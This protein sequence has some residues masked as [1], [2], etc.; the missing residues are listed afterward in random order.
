MQNLLRA[1]E[2]P[3]PGVSLAASTGR[4]DSPFV[5]D[6][7]GVAW[8]VQSGHL[9]LFLV[10]LR[11]GDPIGHRSHVLRASEGELVCGMDVRPDGVALLARPAPETSLKRISPHSLLATAAGARKLEAWCDRLRGA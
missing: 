1:I 6:G 9:D 10:R 5:I 3:R 7:I 11:N 4:S 8:L 2:D